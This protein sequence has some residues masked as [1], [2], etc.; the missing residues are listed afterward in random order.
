MTRTAGPGWGVGLSPKTRTP[1][2]RVRNLAALGEQWVLW[3]SDVHWDNPK[4][5][6]KLYRRHLEQARERNAIVIDNGDF[7]CAMQGTGD[8]RSQKG[9]LRSEHDRPD[10]LSA[11][12]ETAGEFLAPYAPLFAVLGKGNHE[13]SVL[14]HKEVD[15]TRSLARELR[16]RGSPVVLGHY[17]GYIRF[18]FSMYENSS[19]VGVNAFRHH[20]HG[21]GGPVTKGV[22]QANRRAVV[23]AD[24]DWVFTGHIHEGWMVEYVQHRISLQ[25]NEFLRSQWHL[26]IPTY[27][28]EY[29]L[30]RGGFHA[31][32]GRPPKPVGAWW[33]RFY[34]EGNELRW[35]FLRAQ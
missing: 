7:F 4:C 12:T 3:T 9:D 22:I 34:P 20:G 27:K 31:E 21:G 32:R 14:K 24:A 2:V 5:L 1:I 28:R 19:R 11:L 10:Y 33:Q 17:G 13:T 29:N 16:H 23:Y 8:R 26:C 30:A 15:L 35:E 18:Q 6:R 25:G